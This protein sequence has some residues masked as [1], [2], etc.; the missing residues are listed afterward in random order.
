MAFQIRD[1]ILGIWG[2]G[3]ITGKPVAFDVQRR[4]KTLPVVFGLGEAREGEVVELRAIYEKKELSL[5]DIDAVL[6]ILN[7][8]DA[9]AFAQHLAERYY[10]EALHELERTPISAKA[11]KELGALAVF[12]IERDY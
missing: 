2:K 8:L 10:S 11:Q 1:D 12:L 3:E 9:R 5:H 6:R 4:K 7:R